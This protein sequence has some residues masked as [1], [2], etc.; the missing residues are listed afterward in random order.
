M[1]EHTSAKDYNRQQLK[2]ETKQMSE[3]SKEPGSQNQMLGVSYLSGR[4]PMMY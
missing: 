3:E 1:E 4:K 2:Q